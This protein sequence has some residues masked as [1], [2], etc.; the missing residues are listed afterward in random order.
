MTGGTLPDVIVV[1]AGGAG[2]PLA[3]RLAQRG[4]RVLLLEAG[5]VPA[6]AST[7]DGASLAAA[8]PGHALATSYPGTLTTGR[9]H[10]VVRGRVAGGST[11]INGGYFRRPRAHDLDSWAAVADERRW[12]ATDTLPLWSR[13]EADR[14]FGDQLGHG[15]EG[16]LPVT[17]GDLDHPVS[18]A[19]LAGG[20]ELDL[21]RVADHNATPDTGP[22][23]G[24][25]PTNTRGGERWSTA[26]AWLS[27]APPGLELRGGH[28]VVGIVVN[29]RGRA[30]GVDVRVGDGTETLHAGLIVL[31]GGAIATPQLLVRSSIGPADLLTAR[32]LPVVHDAPVGTRLHDHPQVVLRFA[33][34]H[35]ALAHPSDASLGVSAHGSSGVDPEGVGDL[36][37]LSVLRPLGRMLG[38]DAA[39]TNLSLLVSSLRSSAPGRL[40]L[41][42]VDAPHLDFGYLQTEPDRARLRA[43]VR[44]AASLLAS[45]PV[46]QLGARPE[47]PGLTELDDSELDG[48]IR[49]HL[50][51]ALHSCGTTP[52]GTDAATS[53][54]DGRGAVHGVEGLHIADLG[55][56]P[57]TPTGGPAATA[58]LIGEVIADALTEER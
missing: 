51:T 23:I 55:I 48:W 2:A 8:V 19:L 36:E 38:T 57:T 26:R 52:M 43:A 24:P 1:G 5:P 3:A 15:R 9:D 28:T 4:G 33:V 21:P 58:V 13:I 34:P 11:A 50:S 46:Q 16:P 30:I 20:T 47:H 53:V 6:P 27:P 45:G 14:E 12:S 56:L 40:L 10:T 42:T 39:D 29:R 22:G 18:A 54:V 37:V 31:C 17:R 35:E 32:G 41:G 7:R 25:T 44:L 49:D